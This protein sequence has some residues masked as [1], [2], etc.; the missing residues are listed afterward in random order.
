MIRLLN[1]INEKTEHFAAFH[2]RETKMRYNI[3]HTDSNK[4]SAIVDSVGG[5]VISDVNPCTS[6]GTGIAVVEFQDD[7]EEYLDRLLDESDAV[8]EYR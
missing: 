2:E 7:Q 8:V 3:E 6:D 5:V 4:I 1:K